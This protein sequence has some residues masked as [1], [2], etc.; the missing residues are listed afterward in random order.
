MTRQI[1]DNRWHSSPAEI[2]ATGSPV[3]NRL[4]SRAAPIAIKRTAGLPCWKHDLQVSPPCLCVFGQGRAN[5][6]RHRGTARR[7]ALQQ[8]GPVWY[9]GRASS[10]FVASKEMRLPPKLLDASSA[11]ARFDRYAFSVY[12]KQTVETILFQ[13]IVC[14]F[15]MAQTDQQAGQGFTMYM[16]KRMALLAGLF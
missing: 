5:L 14:H 9:S 4:R 10:E 8:I 7:P 1:R 13:G 12:N 16:G 3:R 2:S 15:S 11:V 6:H